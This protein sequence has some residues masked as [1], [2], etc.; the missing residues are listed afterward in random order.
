MEPN[1][2]DPNLLGESNPD[3]FI[4][5]I[6]DIFFVKFIDDYNNTSKVSPGALRKKFFTWP[7]PQLH[8]EPDPEIFSQI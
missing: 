2:S 4:S 8:L 5:S 7:I 3:F 6:F 1:I